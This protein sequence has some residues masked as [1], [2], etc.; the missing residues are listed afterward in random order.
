MAVTTTWNKNSISDFLKADAFAQE[1]LIKYYNRPKL[2]HII[3]RQA[4]FSQIYA[5]IA[6]NTIDVMT[7]A[8][9]N[10]HRMPFEVWLDNVKASSNSLVVFIEGY[11]GC[12]KT[13]FVQK[14]LKE[15]LNTLDYDFNYYNYDIGAYYSNRNSHRLKASIAECFLQQLE[16]C[17]LNGQIIVIN[18]FKELLAQREIKYVDSSFEIYYSFTGTTAF[19]DA[20]S[21]L[22]ETKN[23]PA[24]R[25]AMHEQIKTLGIEQ[26]LALDYLFRIAKYIT[27]DHYDD[28]LYVCYDNMDAIENFDELMSFDNTLVSIRR[29]IDSYIGSIEDCFGDLPVPHFVILATYRKITVAKVDLKQRSERGDDYKEYNR[30]IYYIDASHLYRYQELVRNR[31]NYYSTYTKERSIEA[32]GLLNTLNKIVQLSEM[33]FIQKRYAGLWNN[34]YRVSSDIMQIIFYDYDKDVSKCL[35]LLDEHLDGYDESNSAYYGASAVFLNL[36]CKVFYNRG[37]WGQDHLALIP[38]GVVNS[39]A[40]TSQL[41]SLSRLILTYIANAKEYN[42]LRKPVS[43]RE[44][45]EEFGQLFSPDEICSCLANMLARD[46][47]NTWRRP[48]YYHRNAINDDQQIKQ[49]LKNQW[50]AYD[51]RE[52]SSSINYTEFLLCECGYA[53]VERIVSE[54]EFYSIRIHGNEQVSLYLMHDIGAMKKAINDVLYAVECCCQNMRLFCKRY[55]SKKNIKNINDYIHLPINPRTNHGSPQLHTERT[56]FSHI[57]YLDHCRRFYILKSDIFDEKKQ[58]N[59]LFVDSIESYLSLYREYIAPVDSS[60]HVVAEELEKMVQSNKG[61]ENEDEWLRPIDS[62]EIE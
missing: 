8:E 26:V 3:D 14:F 31:R 37:L 25:L 1:I 7:G 36:I 52:I 21:S 41:T 12:G 23:R 62:N 39:D 24:F 34:N 48:I 5:N 32:Q 50:L 15:Q 45:F 44:I 20:V 33:Y 61:T 42:G 59:T 46:E 27:V 6:D 55:M 30:F 17:I 18:K 49:T 19:E 10:Y 58:M 28:L 56:I 57:S 54:F 40:P 2:E 51:S 43:T 47:T 38:L 60:R 29:N 13:I 22:K 53:Y 16:W 9:L 11:A 4:F 35:D